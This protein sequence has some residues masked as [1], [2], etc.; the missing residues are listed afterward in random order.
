GED[1][2]FLRG[3]EHAAPGATIYGKVQRRANQEPLEGIEIAIEGTAGRREISTA[4]D[5]TYR[6]AALEPGEY[7]IRVVVPGHL[8]SGGLGRDRGVVEHRV[9]VVDRGCAVADFAFESAGRIS[10]RVTEANGAPA[11]DAV[12]SLIAVSEG[13]EDRRPAGWARANEEG[14]YEIGD[15]PPGRYVIA[16]RHDGGYAVEGRR[17]LPYYHP[18]VFYAPDATVFALGEGEHLEGV[19]LAI[20]EIPEIVDVV[21]QVL[22]ADG[23]PPRDEVVEYALYGGG[24]GGGSVLD[25][26]GKM[27]FGAHRGLRYEVTVVVGRA[28]GQGQPAASLELV[29]GGQTEPMTITLPR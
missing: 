23:T 25:E 21:I 18:G 16:A 6:M 4:K 3:L 29:A 15:L 5:G 11:K 1:L 27:T 19:H 13:S 12:V 14:A 17:T 26:Q 10:G 7:T 2:A 28:A 8:K 24:E 22:R 9:R 20:P